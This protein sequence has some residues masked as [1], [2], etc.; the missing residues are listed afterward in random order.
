MLGVG[1]VNMVLWT[2]G[3]YPQIYKNWSR[4]SVSG[5]S[6]DFVGFNLFG[7]LMYSTFNASLYFSSEIK[8]EYSVLYPNAEIPVFLTDVIQSFHNLVM[9]LIEVVQILMYREKGRTI[10]KVCGGL[11]SLWTVAAVVIVLVGAFGKFAWLEV[12]TFLGYGKMVASFCKYAPQ[13]FIHFKEK[14]VKG[15]SVSY[16]LFDLTGSF[17]A[18]LQLVMLAVLTSDP[19]SL[20]GN[21]PKM[22]L[23]C[24]AAGFCILFLVQRFWL[25]RFASVEVKSKLHISSSINSD[26]DCL[27]IHTTTSTTPN[28]LE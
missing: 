21:L 2:I 3:F 15:F 20:L 14:A 6:F 24:V 22:T 11:L 4:K 27:L 23:A 19:F 9:T 1:W 16:I 8:R 12:V 25:Y 17:L 7:Y 10:S 18:V 28:D 26:E 13:G 5:F